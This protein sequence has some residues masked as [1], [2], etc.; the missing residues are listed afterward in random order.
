MFKNVALGIITVSIVGTQVWIG[1][2]Y[3]KFLDGILEKTYG[4]ES[5]DLDTLDLDWE[6]LMEDIE[7]LK[8]E[9]EEF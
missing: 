8:K 7:K 1:V 3:K 9:F 5:E 2:Q 4:S 6:A